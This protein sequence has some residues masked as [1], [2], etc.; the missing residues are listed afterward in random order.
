M[1]RFQDQYGLSEYDADVLVS[2]KDTADFF[3][4]VAILNVN[5]KQ[6]ANWLMGDVSRRL[7]ERD[8][9]IKVTL[10]QPQTLADMIEVIEN[11]RITGK[12][13]RT[14]LLLSSMEHPLKTS[15]KK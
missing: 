3:E 13:A 9:T 6:I 4:Q 5:H 2:E 11:G 7:N 15:S 1:R 12:A 10:L 8:T 14:S